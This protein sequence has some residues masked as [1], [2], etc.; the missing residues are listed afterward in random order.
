LTGVFTAAA[1]L[2]RE[3]LAVVRVPG[4]AARRARG[5]FACSFGAADT[6]GAF[7][8]RGDFTG[9]TSPEAGGAVAS[10]VDAALA[11]ATF[12]RREAPAEAGRAGDAADRRGRAARAPGLRD[13]DSFALITR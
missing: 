8:F 7:F 13:D 1:V 5:A 3:G 12:L 2:R 10:V 9:A 6:A 11:R 4:R